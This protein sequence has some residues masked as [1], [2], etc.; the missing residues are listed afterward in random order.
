MIP[1]DRE[2]PF[3]SS[4]WVVDILQF[5]RLNL[6]E[7]DNAISQLKT[8]KVKLH[9]GTYNVRVIQDAFFQCLV[10]GISWGF[11]FPNPEAQW[12]LHLEHGHFDE[13]ERNQQN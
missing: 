10:T 1:T 9:Q 7:N 8:Q 4:W 5:L 2:R 6:G 11:R 12:L 3:R 13:L